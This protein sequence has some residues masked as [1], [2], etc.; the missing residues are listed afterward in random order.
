MAVGTS[1]D[2]ETPGAKQKGEA[3]ASPQIDRRD[4]WTA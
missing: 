2:G 4:A 3:E 1:H